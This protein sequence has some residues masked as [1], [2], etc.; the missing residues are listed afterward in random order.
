MET[1]ATGETRGTPASRHA[2]VAA[3]AVAMLLEPLEL[4]T[5]AA[6]LTLHTTKQD[7]ETYIGKQNKEEKQSKS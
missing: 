1:P 4:R 7:K 5:S 2:K 3:H 6:T